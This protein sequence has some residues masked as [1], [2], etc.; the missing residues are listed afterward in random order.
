MITIA[1]DMEQ[2]DCPFIETSD[3]HDVSFATLHWDFD[4]AVDELETRIVVE[5]DDRGALENGLHALTDHSNLCDYELLSKRGSTAHIRTVIGETNAMGVIRNSGGYITG[6][7]HIQDGSELWNVGFDSP[8]VTD[9]ALADLEKRNDFDVVSR[10]RLEM[11]TLQRF[12]QNVD[13]GMSLV[14]GCHELSTVERQTLRAAM[15]GGYFDTPREATLADVGEEFGVSS[16][17][18]SKNLRRGQRK[19]IARVVDAL[20]DLD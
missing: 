14:E 18:V 6:P 11:S 19:I 17:A 9:D 15:A 20:D 5:G 16:P 13:V 7:F 4:A 1:M 8:S 12:A 3:D 2:Y 10:E